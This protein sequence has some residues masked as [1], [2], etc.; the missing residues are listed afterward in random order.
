MQSS[1]QTAPL[2]RPFRSARRV[3]LDRFVVSISS[4]IR[5][6]LHKPLK[7]QA[8]LRPCIICGN[9]GECC[10]VFET[11]GARWCRNQGYSEGIPAKGLRLTRIYV[12]IPPLWPVPSDNPLWCDPNASRRDAT[13]TTRWFARSPAREII[14]PARR[15]G[16]TGIRLGHARR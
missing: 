7:Y 14:P 16:V 9:M 10:L 11:L 8:E 2:W 1:L 13:Q 3:Y 4:Q 5:P 6:I 15:P 12:Q